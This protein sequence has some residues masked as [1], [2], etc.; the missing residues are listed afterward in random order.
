VRAFCSGFC[1]D[2]QSKDYLARENHSSHTSTSSRL[3]ES[4]RQA[5]SGSFFEP[6]GRFATQFA[7]L[8]CLHFTPPPSETWSSWQIKMEG[9]DL[10]TIKVANASPSSVLVQAVINI[11][12]PTIDAAGF[13]IIP[14]EKRIECER[15]LQ[16]SADLIAIFSRSSRSVLSPVPC[17]ALVPDGQEER[18]RLN[19]TK[20]ICSVSA[21]LGGFQFPMPQDNSLI[22]SLTDRLAG[23]A[24]MAEAFSQNTSAGKYRE[25]VR[26]FEAAF[27]LRFVNQGKI[28]HR[29]LAPAMGYT[30]AEIGN[31][32]SLRHPMTHADGEATKELA[33]DHDVRPI[34]ARMEQA[35]LDVLFN[36]VKWFTRS[37]DRRVVW[38]PQAITTAASGRGMVRQNSKQNSM[39]FQVIDDFGVFA[40]DLKAVLK[41]LPETWW[42]R[43]NRADNAE[44]TRV[45]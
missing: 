5:I 45:G 1:S 11:P 42:W 40:L 43:A 41:P 18:E 10:S 15:A 27:A 44:D 25:F 31:W 17:W 29:F 6:H 7:R 19:Q 33:F 13:L 20:G 3:L 14:S 21:M 34:I 28:L 30:R 9:V 36:K 37:V 12:F 8:A 26:F 23:V 39:I 22:Q 38:S 2:Q 35:A 4:W 16:F 32:C 24:I